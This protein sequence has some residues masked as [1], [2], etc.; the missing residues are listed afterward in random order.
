MI[1]YLL[2]PLRGTTKAPTLAEK[3]PLRDAFARYGRY[4]ATHVVTTLLVSV[5][6]AAILVYPFPF[7]YTTD[8]I[9]G[10]SILPEHAWTGT[11]PLDDKNR[12]EPDVMMRSIWVHGNYFEALNRNVLL[13]ALELQDQLL[14]PTVNFNPRHQLSRD[15]DVPDAATADLTP[16]Q[17]DAYHVING[18]TNESW[19]FQSPLQY[20][21]CSSEVI[22]RD[23]DIIATANEKRMQPTSVNVTL[24]HS[25][26]FSGKRFQDRELVAADAL[27]ITLVHHRDSPVGRLWQER[28]QTLKYKAMDKWD[29]F[30]YSHS[31]K[32]SEL[33][34]FQFRP[35][36]SLDIFLLLLA[37]SLVLVYFLASLS[38]L[39]AVKSKMG[40]IVTITAQIMLAILSSFTVCAVL[41]IDLSR[42]PRFG[43]PVVIFS[44]SLENVF[45]LINAVILT[46]SEG[47]T[48]NRI[49]Q[50]FGETG[51]VALASVAQNLLILYGL[52]KIVSP[53]V[54][55]FCVFA[56]I[57]LVFDFFYLSTFFLSVLSVD[58]RR[59]ELG[60]A[61]AKASV[62]SRR[63]ALDA[64]SRQTWLDAMLEGRIA[65]STRVAGTIVM[66]G[67]VLIAQWHFFENESVARTL[68][69]IIRIAPKYK[70][71]S[72]S[73]P[74]RNVHLGRSPASWLGL[75]GHQTARELIQVVKPNAHSYVARVFHPTIFVLKG[76]D[77]NLSA[78]DPWFPPAVYDFVRH[79]SIPFLVIVLVI[80]AAVRLL[81]NYLLWDELAD[82]AEVHTPSTDSLLSVQTLSQGHSLDVALL[83]ACCDGHL[84]SVGLDRVIRVWNM[85]AGGRS[86]VLGED[87]DSS[88][89]P[90]PILA[91]CIEEESHWLAL[92]T[93]NRVLLWNLADFRWGPTIE[94]EADRH[95]PEA[96]FFV[97][98]DSMAIPGLLLIG[99]DGIITELSTVRTEPS[100]YLLAGEGA[101]VSVGALAERGFPA[102]VMVSTREGR[103][104]MASQEGSSWSS[105]AVPMKAPRD[106]EFI[107]IQALPELGFFLVIRSQTADLVDSLTLRAIYTFKVD[108]IHPKSMKCFHSR[109]RR[110]RCGSVALWSFTLA[111]INT[112]TRDLIVQTYSPQHEGESLCFCD[113]AAPTRK[114]CCPWQRAR[115]SRRVIKNPGVWD[116]LP[117]GIIVGVRRKLAGNYHTEPQYT[118]PPLQQLNGLRRRRQVKQ[119]TGSHTHQDNWEIWVFSHFGKQESWETAPLCPEIEDDGHLFVTNLGPMVRVGRSSVAVG[120][121]NVIKVIMVGNERFET[122]EDSQPGDGMP[123][124][125]SRRRKGPS[126]LRGKPT[127]QCPHC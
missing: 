50:A 80:A 108:P 41:K 74:L 36:S 54:S 62:R 73:S 109:P 47:S 70:D 58:V 33:Y 19:F 55:A 2:Y 123:A 35:L 61:L 79:Q 77:R 66:V 3:N 104:W 107:S 84:V 78:N 91:M 20:W 10:A 38:K 76:S 45:R 82:A 8:F 67:F 93:S 92:L 46:P 23:G 100:S 16:S 106:R 22:E 9:Y 52:S 21:S 102:Q 14:G 115:E 103:V 31:G 4:A 49:G 124:L 95:K 69:R 37:Y 13:S 99:R 39:R 125:G 32:T 119:P 5:S 87:E 12:A 17:R 40:L 105:N 89:I 68:G 81:M 110:M 65:M 75:Q 101:I 85:K 116:A 72:L 29:M 122:G 127:M 126:T 43:Y 88:S 83:S 117:S 96:F 86:Y 97:P 59:T 53:G 30:E 118:P 57:A 26:V 44:M 63:S 56:A 94:F 15:F 111:Y 98:D 28:I 11:L 25:T 121:S 6:V 18:L 7:L 27:V 71:L 112:Y 113:P 120:L 34:E 1:W 24:R 60:D 64:Q 90:F 42:L 51:H 48:S 114:T